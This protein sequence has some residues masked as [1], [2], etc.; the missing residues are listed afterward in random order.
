MK[1]IG[2]K[3]IKV[4]SFKSYKGNLYKYVSKK[5]SYFKSFGEIYLN[6]INYKMKK[7]WILHKK[8]LCIITVSYGN[9]KF[10]LIDGRKKSKSFN[11]EDNI[12]MSTKKHSV[13]VIP[14]GVWFSFTTELKKSV[15]LNLFDRVHYDHEATKQNQIKDYF[16]K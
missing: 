11:K 2:V 14:P 9:V 16:I 8:N 6:E 12:T 7:G 13:L 5:S 15:I 1:I 3:K 10:K 4:K